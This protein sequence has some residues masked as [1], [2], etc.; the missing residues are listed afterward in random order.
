M[1]VVTGH[2]Y[3]ARGRSFP[4]PEAALCVA[5][6]FS[7]VRWAACTLHSRIHEEPIRSKLTLYLDLPDSG[8]DYPLGGG[9][10]LKLLEAQ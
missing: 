7:V 5:S 3:S 1:E 8:G 2:S 4:L 9:K 6:F 10:N